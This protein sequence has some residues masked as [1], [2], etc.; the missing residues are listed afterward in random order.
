MPFFGILFLWPA[1]SGDGGSSVSKPM[2][3][4]QFKHARSVART[5]TDF[6]Q[7]ARYANASA[8]EYQRRAAECEAELKGYESGAVREPLVPKYPTRTQTLRTL[9]AHYR[10]AE[11][12]WSGLEKV[13]L[14][15][16]GVH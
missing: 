12:H 4:H 6:E 7:L 13:Y 1:L 15:K 3:A 16:A 9:I 14:S 2:T 8:R 11:T 5:P 10:D